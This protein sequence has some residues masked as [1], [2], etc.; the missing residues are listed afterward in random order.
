MKIFWI[1]FKDGFSNPTDLTSG[2]TFDD[3]RLS[4]TYDE[5]VNFGQRLRNLISGRGYRA[6]FELK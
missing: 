3:Q 2:I 1:G 4:N 6:D 5:G